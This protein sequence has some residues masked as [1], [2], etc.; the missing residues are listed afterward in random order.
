MSLLGS[1]VA[2]AA[3][4]TAATRLSSSHKAMPA[5]QLDAWH[6]ASI[7]PLDRGAVPVLLDNHTTGAR[8][9]LDIC[10]RGATAAP[11]AESRDFA[12]Y[13]ANKGSGSSRTAREDTLVAR[14][15]AR[16]LDDEHVEVPASLLSM[17]ARLAQHPGLF[18]SSDDDANA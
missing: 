14:A 17:D 4:V 16:R 10:A 1:S 15:L 12:I 3:A 2:G 13:L 18:D 8:L 7:E 9:R 11:V 5:S 6:I